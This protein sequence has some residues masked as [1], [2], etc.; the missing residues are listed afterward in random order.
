MLNFQFDWVSQWNI[1]HI[2]KVEFLWVPTTESAQIF[3]PGSVCVS[4][5]WV[6]TCHVHVG[7]CRF[8]KVDPNPALVVRPPGGIFNERAARRS[9]STSRFGCVFVCLFVCLFVPTC[10]WAT[11]EQLQSAIIIASVNR[12]DSAFTCSVQLEELWINFKVELRWLL[13]TEL[14]QI[15]FCDSMCVSSTW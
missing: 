15:F 7:T 9:R 14:T 1:P 2:F 10:S 8:M 6:T 12:I 4:S 5:M 13:I 3:F 11:Q